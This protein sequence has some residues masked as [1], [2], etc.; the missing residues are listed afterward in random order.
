[1]SKLTE[2]ASGQITNSD[3][4]T[5]ILSEPDHMRATVVV[6]WPSRQPTVINPDSFGDTAAVIVRIFST[7]HIALAQIRRDRRL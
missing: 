3:A 7:A 4:I 2:L 1:M 6:H 5:A